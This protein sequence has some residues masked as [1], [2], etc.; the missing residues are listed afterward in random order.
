MEE[1]R[2]GQSAENIFEA[3]D[4]ASLY[5]LLKTEMN[6]DG[7]LDL[8]RIRE[9]TD[10]LAQREDVEVPDPERAWESFRETHLTTEPMY[11]E[12]DGPE[13]TEKAQPRRALSAK[14]RRRLLRGGMVAAIMLTFLLGATATAHAAGFDLWAAIGNWTRE[15]FYFTFSGNQYTSPE[16]EEL[17]DTMAE[18]D[19]SLPTWLPEGYTQ[20]VVWADAEIGLWAAIYENESDSVIMSI[21]RVQGQSGIT[22][23]KDDEAPEIY[24]T[25][26]VDYY[27]MTNAGN[28]QAVWTDGTYEYSIVTSQEDVLYQI[29]DS[30]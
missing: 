19:V 3:M 11:P 12:S 21:H 10:V 20:D 30:I 1:K 8:A 17:W 14:G 13:T 25:R 28:F 26:G 22:Y 9:I 27:I 23:E 2:F 4:T 15:A 29:I 16:L 5:A 24:S 18:E 6:S 7:E